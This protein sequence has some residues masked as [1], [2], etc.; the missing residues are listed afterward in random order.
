MNMQ[1][2]P[3]CRL[4]FFLLFVFI[5]T[6]AL[7]LLAFHPGASSLAAGFTPKQQTKTSAADD[8]LG[9]AVSY[10]KKGE[11]YQNQ[12]KYRQAAENYQKAIT[13]DSSYA[14]AYSNLGFSYRKQGQFDKAISTYKKAIKLKPDLA[15]AHEYIGE[16][17]AE[18]GE[19]D[20]AEEHL[21]I[22]KNLH[23]DEAP[24]LEDF[25]KKQQ[26]AQ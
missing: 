22:L 1:A 8:N 21:S 6:G 16:A 25:I 13:I 18:M 20:R 4:L 12:G 9:R 23:S 17:Y 11:V 14:E 26:A 19:F 2:I 5:F 10:F 3:N 24:A 15:E 7:S